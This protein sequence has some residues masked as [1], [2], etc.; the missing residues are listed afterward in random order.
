MKRISFFYVLLII[1]CS[2]IMSSCGNDEINY[3]SCHFE[4][5]GDTVWDIEGNAYSVVRIGDQAW[6]GENLKTVH[7]ANGAVIDNSDDILGAR[8]YNPCGH[9]DSAKVYGKLYNWAAARGIP[10]TATSK[11]QVQGICPDG[12]HLPSDVEWQELVDYTTNC[13]TSKARTSVAKRLAI[14]DSCWRPS[15]IPNT[16]GNVPDS[17]NISH[18]G[19]IPSGHCFVINGVN[20]FINFHGGAHFWS[21]T[22]YG[23]REDEASLS[24]SHAYGRYIGHNDVLA[25]K[26]VSN[27]KACFSVRCIKD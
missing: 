23:H 15:T 4:V 6:L 1:S 12:F 18:F 2:L 10:D 7:Y 11:S 20:K 24:N 19:A 16:P 5:K 22:P 9:P 21:S 3:G 17:N 8:C 13:S 14:N 25:N 27:K 26:S